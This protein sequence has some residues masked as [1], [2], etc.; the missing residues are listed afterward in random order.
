MAAQ[1]P[2]PAYKLMLYI[3][4]ILQAAYALAAPAHPSHLLK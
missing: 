4:V 3:P 2:Y 1:A